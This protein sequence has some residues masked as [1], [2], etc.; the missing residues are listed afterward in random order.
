MTRLTQTNIMGGFLL[1][2]H[3]GTSSKYIEQLCYLHKMHEQ[4][5]DVSDVEA[6]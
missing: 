5:N 3:V 6:G 2:P 1:L 4:S